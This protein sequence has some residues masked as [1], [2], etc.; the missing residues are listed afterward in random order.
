MFL[1]NHKQLGW[2]DCQQKDHCPHHYL[3]QQRQRMTYFHLGWKDRRFCKMT[4]AVI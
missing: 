1:A 3:Y 4:I 2:K